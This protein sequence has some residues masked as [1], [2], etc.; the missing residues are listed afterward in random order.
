MLSLREGLMLYHGSYTPVAKPNLAKCARFKDFGRG[1][2]LTSS[3]SQAQSFARLSL[4]KAK[5]NELVEPDQDVGYVSRFRVRAF[6]PHAISICTF[7]TANT[8]WLR[9][10]AAH[11]KRGAFVRDLAI[12]ES[13]D[14]II[15]KVADDQTNNTLVTFLSGG[16]GP[17]ESQ[18]AME[19]CIGL[20]LPDRLD[21]QYCF[22]T[23]RALSLLDYVECEVV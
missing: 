4:R 17:F 10:I 13:Y 20:L 23:D 14:V 6:S 11:R 21:D 15:G 19:L 12:L 16:Y 9:C 2:Y 1:F 3:L 5:E 8:A 22:R 7:Q 18:A